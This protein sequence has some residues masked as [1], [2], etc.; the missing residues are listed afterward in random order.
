MDD[1]NPPTGSVPEIQNKVPKPPGV[2]P[3]NRQT[4]VMLAVGGLIALVIAFSNSSGTPK[5]KAAPSKTR[6]QEPTPISPKSVQQYARQLEE[7]TKNLAQ[8]R[9]RAEQMRAEAQRLQ[10]G[11]QNPYQNPYQPAPVPMNASGERQP[12]VRELQ[13]QAD[14]K[15]EEDSLRASNIALSFRKD[16]P[17]SA[18]D[19]PT[20][21]SDLSDVR[22]L[23][24][25]QK[26]ALAATLQPP[27]QVWPGSAAAAPVAPLPSSTR[28]DNVETSS[29]VTQRQQDEALQQSTGKNRRVF[30]G[31][32]IET[33]LTNRLNGTFSGPVNALVTTAVYSR[34]GQ[35][36]LIPQGTRVIGDVQRVSVAGQQRLAVAFHRMIMPDGYS[37]NLDQFRGLN[38]IGETGL[39][40]Q[41]NQHY[42]QIFGTSLALGAIAGVEQARG[43]Y[44]YNTSGS[45]IY[46]Q[47]VAQSL[48]GSATRILDH[49]L[50]VL[51]TVTIREGHRIKVYLT[52]DLLLPA[53]ENHR[54]ASDL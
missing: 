42:L 43:S 22:Q 25:A 27:S 36:V 9:A 54:I 35:H 13:K 7:D 48:S 21:N 14:R 45:D 34:D 28:E 30:E 51:P 17:S 31:T 23:I 47:G 49:F 16:Q 5:P 50:N 24:E 19:R 40:D 8:E 6:G 46:R 15:R 52:G 29:P 39:K 44:G 11:P 38:Q 33:V 3:K 53:Y 2:S 32:T 1:Q 41:V 18:G 37:L 12:S 26:A 4:I 20:M 10:P